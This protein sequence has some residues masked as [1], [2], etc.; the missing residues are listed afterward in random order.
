MFKAEGVEVI[1]E[2]IKLLGAVNALHLQGEGDWQYFEHIGLLPLTPDS[3]IFVE[4]MLRS[5]KSMIVEVVYQ[6]SCSKL[7]NH[8]ELNTSAERLPLKIKKF[9]WSASFFPAIYS[10]LDT[11]AY[12]VA[13]IAWTYYELVSWESFVH[14]RV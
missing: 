14:E 10:K 1:K 3:H 6:L 8:V 4:L 13:I 12:D 7:V 2:F 5:Q 11:L 9:V